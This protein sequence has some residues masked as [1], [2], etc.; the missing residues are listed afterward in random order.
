MV[1]KLSFKVLGIP[2]PHLLVQL[3]AL[4]TKESPLFLGEVAVLGK[5][6]VYRA[7]DGT[8]SVLEPFC[9]QRGPDIHMIKAVTGG[10]VVGIAVHQSGATVIGEYGVNARSV[11]HSLVDTLPAERAR[12]VLGVI[13]PV[14]PKII[15]DAVDAGVVNCGRV[16][17]IYVE[18][19]KQVI[20]Y[21]CELRLAN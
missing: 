21:V 14:R 10:P 19:R 13:R 7:D 1:M 11:L 5:G 12:W 20:R 2:V 18:V 9:G 17:W 4:V 6:D 16:S 3:G 15:C 8:D